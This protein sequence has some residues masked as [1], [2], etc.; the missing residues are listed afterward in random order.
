MESGEV[1]S[2]HHMESG[3]QKS[4]GEEAGWEEEDGGPGEATGVSPYRSS[5]QS[6]TS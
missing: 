6:G 3:R 5:S 1:G 4:M 2:Q